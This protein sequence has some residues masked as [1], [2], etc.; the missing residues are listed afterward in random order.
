MEGV[1]CVTLFSGFQAVSRV[2]AS[3]CDLDM[4]VYWSDY[5][6]DIDVHTLDPQSSLYIIKY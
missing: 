3:L 2:H 6:L 5:L 4:F 1:L